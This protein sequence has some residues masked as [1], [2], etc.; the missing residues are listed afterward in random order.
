MIK[1]IALMGAGSLGTTLGAFL[2]K[3]GHDITLVDAYKD[4]VDALNATGA[5]II[6]TIDE[7]IPV[8][9][10]LSDEMEGEFDLFIYMA[11]QTYNDVAVPQMLAH[12]HDKTII[13][14]CQN[15][16]PEPALAKYMPADRIMG[17]P[18]GWGGIFQ[19]PGCTFLT[20]APDKMFCSL[21]T[22]TGEHTPELDEVAAIMQ[23]GNGV[24]I[25]DN[26]MGLR[27]CKLTLNACF[28][29]LSTV[30]GLTFG[31]I[32]DRPELMKIICYLGRECVLVCKASG[33]KMEPF[34]FGDMAYEFDVLYDFKGDDAPVQAAIDAAEGY[35]RPAGNKTLASMLQDIQHGRK[36]E[37]DAIPGAV[38][39]AARQ[40]GIQVPVMEQIYQMIKRIENGEMT[41]KVENAND[42]ILK[43]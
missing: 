26:L 18:I 20:A 36:T 8:K 24:A 3:A 19:G 40:A 15:G 25:S 10:C 23:D 13:V 2:S 34:H 28:S 35:L 22:Y 14:A 30:T 11:K 39:E 17:A 33:V 1:R 43:Q 4:H 16:L 38:V 32:I 31:E 42:L 41:Y 7:V 12:S 21:G 6:G 5:H 37:V 29:S 9:A 27:W